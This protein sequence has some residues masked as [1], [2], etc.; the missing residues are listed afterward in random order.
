MTR[1]CVS[2]IMPINIQRRFF[3]AVSLPSFIK[4]RSLV[5]SFHATVNIKRKKI[6]DPQDIET[7]LVNRFTPNIPSPIVMKR[8]STFP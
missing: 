5:P 7:T 1:L 8:Q 2:S 4:L 3:S 6:R